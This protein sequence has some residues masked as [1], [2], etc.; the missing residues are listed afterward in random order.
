MHLDYDVHFYYSKS[1]LIWSNN[2]IT[3]SYFPIHLTSSIFLKI[4]NKQTKKDK[5][6]FLFLLWKCR[7]FKRRQLTT[8][9][10]SI[11]TSL[12]EWL[13]LGVYCSEN[14]ECDKKKTPLMNIFNF[15]WPSIKSL[16]CRKC[17][18][19]ILWKRQSNTCKRSK[20]LGRYV[21]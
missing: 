6:H 11:N 4:L 17:F 19:A 15:S 21:F 10:P 9:L 13:D 14:A 16:I 2:R 12:I 7:I 3:S 8:K 18:A 5:Y 20:S 1:N